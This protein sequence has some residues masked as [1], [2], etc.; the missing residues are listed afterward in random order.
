MKWITAR[1]NKHFLVKEDGEI[2]DEV[3]TNMNFDTFRVASTNKIY[4][5]LEQAKKAS[6]DNYE[7]EKLKA[8]KR[9]VITESATPP[10]SDLG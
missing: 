7:T 8:S 2:V 6:E 9:K 10:E 3:N 5:S 4:I 1:F